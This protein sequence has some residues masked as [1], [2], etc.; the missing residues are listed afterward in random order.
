MRLNPTTQ[1]SYPTLNP[2]L[3]REVFALLNGQTR[4]GTGITLKRGRRVRDG[5]GVLSSCCFCC[6]SKVSGTMLPCRWTRQSI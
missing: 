6:H 3:P 5:N 4:C 2:L 1:P